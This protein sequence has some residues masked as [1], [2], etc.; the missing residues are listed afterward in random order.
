MTEWTMWDTLAMIVGYAIVFY[1]GMKYAENRMIHRMMDM[2][3]DEEVEELYALQTK[4]AELD[5]NDDDKAD[6]I[7]D[8]ALRQL[9]FEI[10]DE[11]IEN[12]SHYFYTHKGEFLC[13]GTSRE[14]AVSNFLA[15]S[16]KDCCIITPEKQKLYVIDGAIKESL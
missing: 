1:A 13:Q 14:E 6:A 16:K 3:T 7:L 15:K 11:H 4:L 9:K 10:I 12:G 8:D 5:P 2:L